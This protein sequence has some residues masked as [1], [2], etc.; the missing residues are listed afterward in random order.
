MSTASA[1]PERNIAAGARTG[2]LHPLLARGWHAGP[3]RLDASTPQANPCITSA[4]YLRTIIML[5]S[6]ADPALIPTLAGEQFPSVA[7]LSRPSRC[8]LGWAPSSR[9]PLIDG[10][11]ESR[12]TRAGIH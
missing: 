2:G 5:C 10:S 11:T 8:E 1:A 3:L 6:R 12:K 7:R 4:R 9:P